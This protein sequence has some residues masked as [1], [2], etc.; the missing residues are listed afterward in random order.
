MHLSQQMDQLVKDRLKEEKIHRILL[1]L[2]L[3]ATK[4]I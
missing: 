1:K 3:L 4:L 2:V